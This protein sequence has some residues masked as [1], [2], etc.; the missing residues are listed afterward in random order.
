M[1]KGAT[2]WSSLAIR[3]VTIVLLSIVS[4]AMLPAQTQ[5]ETLW[6]ACRKA[7]KK[8]LPA[9]FRKQLALISTGAKR[10]KAASDYTEAAVWSFFS[11]I[12]DDPAESLIRLKAQSNEAWLP[13]CD[14]ALLKAVLIEA[15]ARGYAN[16]QGEGNELRTEELP[17]E[18]IELW[19]APQYLKEV[20]REWDQFTALSAS[21]THEST[22]R[23][24]HLYT[25]GNASGG[26]E[27]NLR[28]SLL[29]RLVNLCATKWA[30]L[31]RLTYT[32][33]PEYLPPLSHDVQNGIK[34]GSFKPDDLPKRCLYELI[35]AEKEA[36]NVAKKL[37]FQ[38]LRGEFLPEEATDERLRWL[39]ALL[40]KYALLLPQSD[41]LY[42]TYADKVD[43]LYQADRNRDAV[44]LCERILSQK[45]RGH[46]AQRIRRILCA[47]KKPMF[48][49]YVSGGV[50]FTGN[51]PELDVSYKGIDRITLSIYRANDAKAALERTLQ[52]H[53]TERQQLAVLEKAA[54]FFR[55]DTIDLPQNNDY[56]PNDTT[57]FLPPLPDGHYLIKAKMQPTDAAFRKKTQQGTESI[58]LHVTNV[59][60]LKRATGDSCEA[61]IVDARE[62]KPI[63]GA[64]LQL[65]SDYQKKLLSL[66]FTADKEG[67]VRFRTP[68]RGYYW[69][70]LAYT[71]QDTYAPMV[72]NFWGRENKSK[73][74]SL[75]YT[76]F[77]DRALYRPGQKV[78]FKGIVFRAND[79][80]KTPLSSSKQK[81]F[82]YNFTTGE[83]T[84]LGTY[85]TNEMGS[86]TG[87][88]QLP[89][90]MP[91]ARCQIIIEGN[92]FQ[93]SSPAD[94]RVEAYKRPTYEVV[95]DSLLSTPYYGRAL[96]LNASVR[97]YS[98]APVADA[99]V[100]YRL[101]A[102]EPF[103]YFWADEGDR[104]LVA[105]GNLTTDSFG[106]TTLTLPALRLSA[107][108][109]ARFAAT[110]RT[111]LD[112][113]WLLFR[114]EITVTSREGETHSA[115]YIF[116]TGKE[117][118]HLS[119]SLAKKQPKE[120]L[121]DWRITAK[122]YNDKLLSLS[123]QYRIV[124]QTDTLK[125]L[126]SGT[127]ESDQPIDVHA[128][129]ALPDG[130]YRI[131]LSANYKGVRNEAKEDFLLF[132]LHNGPAVCRD[133]LFIHPIS[134]EY[135]A[136]NPAKLLISSAEPDRTVYWY[137]FTS[138]EDLRS[139]KLVLDKEQRIL[140]FPI[141]KSYPE[142]RLQLFSICKGNIAQEEF[143]LT[144]RPEQPRPELKVSFLRKQYQPSETVQISVSLADSTGTRYPAEL[145]VWAFDA[146]LNAFSSYVMPHFTF[147]KPYKPYRAFI[148][149]GW[150]T[151]TYIG[152][153]CQCTP[154]AEEH[155]QFDLFMPYSFQLE[156]M[157]SG[158]LY[159]ARA[160]YAEMENS[161]AKAA[162][163]ATAAMDVEAQND[164][165]GLQLQEIVVTGYGSKTTKANANALRTDFSETAV[166]MPFVKLS[167]KGDASV[168]FSLPH[169]L[170]RYQ[171]CLFAHNKTMDDFTHTEHFV[172]NKDLTLTTNFPRYLREGDR[173]TVAAE[174]H[175]QGAEPL[176]GN[177]TLDIL[178]VLTDQPLTSCV[179]PFALQGQSDSVYTFELP[180]T[181]GQSAVKCRIVADAGRISDGEER[182]MPQFAIRK[183]FIESIPFLLRPGVPRV[184]NLGSLFS[185]GS[186]EAQNRTLRL[187]ATANPLWSAL[188]ALPALITADETDALRNALTL[189]AHGV[190]A[191]LLKEQPAFRRLLQLRA[192]TGVQPAGNLSKP[193]DL[194]L[195]DTDKTPFRRDAILETEQINR[196][197]LL[198]DSTQMEA[199]RS[200]A[201][202]ALRKVQTSEGGISWFPG[203][204][205]NP[206]ITRYTLLL[207][208]KM[209]VDQLDKELVA[210]QHD[211]YAYLEKAMNN[212]YQSE[213][214][215]KAFL[216]DAEKV[217]WL[218][219]TALCR[220]DKLTS[221]QGATDAFYRQMQRQIP[222][223]QLKV[224][225]RFIVVLQKAGSTAQA[226]RAQERLAEYLIPDGDRG[227][228]L[229]SSNG[230]GQ[231]A[232]WVRVREQCAAIEALSLFPDQA[233][234]V[235]EMKVW[236]LNKKHTAN[237]GDDISTLC[238]LTALFDGMGSLTDYNGSVSLTLPDGEVFRS[239]ADPSAT[240]SGS[241]A[242]NKVLLLANGAPVP[243]S[244][245]ALK[246]GK[247]IARGAVT[248]TFTHPARGIEAA[249]SNELAV[250]RKMF[251][252]VT[253]PN[254][255]IRM[256]PL[257]TL[258]V[259]TL[260]KGDKITVELL[261]N[262]AQD[263]DFVVVKDMRSAALEP[264][265][266]LSGYIFN[267][268]GLSFYHEIR[269]AEECFYIEHLPK[270]VHRLS[271]EAT[272]DRKGNF[273]GGVTEVQSA[274]APDYN[275][276]SAGKAQ[277]EVK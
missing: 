94:F 183:P 108:D 181:E 126:L 180:Y 219:L 5:Y 190:A 89:A 232:D 258:A 157:L 176:R 207:L 19:S 47:I 34:V 231:Y 194:R 270:G 179:L 27:H 53:E 66:R 276:R 171:L 245:T 74:T 82:L 100:R 135:S 158:S 118:V 187:E 142:A 196:L 102:C 239:S 217:D 189:Y 6:Q 250:S 103:R 21:L 251:R 86:F 165:S 174:L 216:T 56:Q 109:S 188:D 48:Q 260:Q 178:D 58:M 203:M 17:L 212:A 255:T 129:K 186:A 38:K 45:A 172:V 267:G 18:Q 253:A 206:F 159:G 40:D 67:I 128:L 184:L 114:Y 252:S 145:A 148:K 9:T 15:Y 230:F 271:Y 257:D 266:T 106:R 162:R 209:P 121:S 167:P 195:A 125:T 113:T 242:I 55:R 59:L 234:K 273:F 191:S 75:S 215:K 123:G 200:R 61:L 143:I 208:T 225:S 156:R 52:S 4:V 43:L 160:V 54:H 73:E 227:L 202:I 263:M 57:L 91:P 110:N 36:T 78:S 83:R 77:T 262:A 79:Q 247:G 272:V 134:T 64:A 131:Y 218:Y 81:L 30:D 70:T 205:A 241:P 112:E 85:T 96:T 130:Y 163:P 153:V 31:A 92:N 275:A 238:A 168:S 29:E 24:P 101:I 248:A 90:D 46:A 268:K 62:G 32:V 87:T 137:L 11:E 244:V 124:S 41:Y 20:C 39:D 246:E 197:T 60:S 127:F 265:V 182:L 68:E 16:N 147:Y 22:K 256:E 105:E 107:A 99:D 120:Q 214:R 133:M 7:Q 154:S 243:Q 71:E 224:L 277:L 151:N 25:F 136:G 93:S 201:L 233:P 14:R 28:Y 221:R 146:A 63:A 199:S 95:I 175:N 152:L 192:A 50:C 173:S 235:E 223:L 122:E 117:R 42:E 23:Y 37:M 222:Q 155:W 104:Y 12:D 8:N 249:S 140:E 269:D 139:G 185:G 115:S 144:K 44:E 51:Q 3:L 177:I 236:L 254:G 26:I 13:A 98:S 49:M 84:D 150:I 2:R 237:W 210:L 264:G 69:R 161:C 111:G 220:P 149:P 259:N 170:T 193:T 228:T 35:T 261:I 240:G 166:W 76:L 204:P 164:S 119:S 198:L 65:Q 213:L 33:H 138:E 169:S 10:D 72:R 97:R 132:G 274:Y 1:E 141:E 226:L 116:F 80:E 88:T 211:A 229:R